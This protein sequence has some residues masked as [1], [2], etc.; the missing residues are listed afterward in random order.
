[1]NE[2][3]PFMDKMFD[4]DSAADTLDK[5]EKRR[6]RQENAAKFVSIIENLTGDNMVEPGVYQ[7]SQFVFRVGDIKLDGFIARKII[8]PWVNLKRYHYIDVYYSLFKINPESEK[9]SHLFTVQEIYLPNHYDPHTFWKRDIKLTNA[10]GKMATYQDSLNAYESAK[11]IEYTAGRYGNM[12]YEE[13]P[14]NQ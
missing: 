10:N 6:L 1:M 13:S 7:S 11:I 14:N 8:D 3:N 5:Y 9:E 12:H 4:E 2:R